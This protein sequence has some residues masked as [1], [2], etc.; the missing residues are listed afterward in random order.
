MELLVLVS[1]CILTFTGKSFG[2]ETGHVKIKT[3]QD[4]TL[5]CYFGKTLLDKRINWKKDG[6]DIFLYEN[7]Q[8]KPSS[9]NGQCKVRVSH[10]KD[11]L[12]SGN[13][14][15]TIK[16]A[17]VSDSGTYICLFY[18][19]GRSLP[20]GRVEIKLTV[21][22]VNITVDVYEDVILPCSFNTSFTD[23]SFDWKKDG[24]DVFFFENG[25]FKHLSQDEQ[26][27]GRVSHFLDELKCGNASITIKQVNL[28]DSGTYTCLYIDGKEEGPRQINLTVEYI[29]KDRSGGKINGAFAKPSA[30]R[31]HING[32]GALLR[33][34]VLGASPEPTVV[35]YDSD[36]NNVSDRE[37]EVSEEGDLYHIILETKVTKTDNY[38]CVATQNEL[39]HQ[40]N[41]TTSVNIRGHVKIKTDQDVTLPC[42]FG[43][44]LLDKRIN[45]KKDGKDIFLYENGQVKPSSQNRQ[46]KVRVSHFKDELK[47]GNA[48]IT[49]KQ[50]KVSDSGT[51][52]CLFYERGRILPSGRV[53]IKLT[54]DKTPIIIKEDESVIL[55][56]SFNTSLTDNR[57]DWKKDGKEVFL[58]E[59]GKFKPSSQDEQFK[60][61]V[62]HFPDE[63]KCGNA[64]ITIKQVKMSDSGTYT[65]LYLD[66]KEEGPRQMNLTVEHI[67]KDRSGGKINGNGLLIG[68]LIGGIIVIGVLTAAV[69]FL[70]YKR[71]RNRNSSGKQDD[72]TNGA[73]HPLTND[74]MRMN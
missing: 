22:P 74:P 42:Y 58:F 64:S 2:D 52:I 21:D 68:G 63:L 46:C 73:N 7:G 37:P 33:C 71:R 27:K 5:P 65:C 26:F 47:S 55:P 59:N 62:S 32:E 40:S 24:K 10:F 53:E 72:K 15:I 12:K 66:G 45:W 25:K 57:F 18:E 16:Q 28:S 67:L 6:K 13:A 23:K 34:E 44:T 41:K 61:R 60:G 3:D 35:W 51:Y 29:L 1:F 70:L 14:S 39:Y 56:C 54:V 4:V 43:R 20:S 8:V 30:F 48:S 36:G 9:Q 19:Q 31:L 50:A 69:A 11:E 49:I 38:T 17:K